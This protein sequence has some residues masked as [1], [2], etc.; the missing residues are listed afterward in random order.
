MSW[1]RRGT[2]HG[3]PPLVEP[4]KVADLPAV[5]LDAGASYLGTYVAGDLAARVRDRGL[6]P[7]GATR[8]RLSDEALDVVRLAGPFRVPVA[9]LRG[10]R[11]TEDVGG[12]P[13][14]PHGAL[15]FTWEHGGLVL[16]TAFRLVDLSFD[17]TSGAASKQDDWVRKI[18]KLVRKQ[19]DVA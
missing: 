19:E 9:A 10:A 6:R 1:L 17:G 8:L 5:L 4:P 14:P 15:V 12:R 7:T 2:R 13:V 11:R 18:S 3:L 16:D